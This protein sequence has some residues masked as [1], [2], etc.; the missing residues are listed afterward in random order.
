MCVRELARMVFE[1]SRNEHPGKSRKAMA[2]FT[3]WV[4]D[5]VVTAKGKLEL[6][7]GCYEFM[8]EMLGTIVIEHV[9]T[10]QKEYFIEDCLYRLYDN[11]HT[12]R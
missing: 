6:G 12:I 9:R 4:T 11:M 7:L 5:G 8:L 1:K 2:M 3:E 10:K